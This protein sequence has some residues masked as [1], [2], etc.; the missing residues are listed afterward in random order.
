MSRANTHMEGK[1]F[2]TT[3]GPSPKGRAVVL[4]CGSVREPVR[5]TVTDDEVVPVLASDVQQG[6]A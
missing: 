5:G 1:A 2:V 4:L 6:L 3:N